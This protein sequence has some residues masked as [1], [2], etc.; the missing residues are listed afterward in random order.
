M[1]GEEDL[2]KAMVHFDKLICEKYIHEFARTMAPDARGFVHHSN[3]GAIAPSDH[4]N[5]MDGPA[6]RSTMSGKL[7]AEYCADAGLVIERQ[8]YLRWNSIDDLDCISLFRKPFE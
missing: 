1:R 8:V 3:Y 6:W 2:E 4:L 5:W 7:F